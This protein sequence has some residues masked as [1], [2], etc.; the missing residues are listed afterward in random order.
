MRVPSP[1]LVYKPIAWGCQAHCCSIST[2]P[3]QVAKG[4]D[5]LKGIGLE[6]MQFLVVELM[7]EISPNWDARVHAWGLGAWGCWGLGVWGLEGQGVRVSG[8]FS[9]SPTAPVPPS[10]RSLLQPERGASSRRGEHIQ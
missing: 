4:K 2:L 7:Q 1:L 6:H 10:H 9:T 5:S 3:G 8:L